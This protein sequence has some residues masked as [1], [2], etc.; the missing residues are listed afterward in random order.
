MDE[1]PKS[2][3]GDLDRMYY[4]Q[5]NKAKKSVRKQE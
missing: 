2:F 5:I 4:E 1:I 3:D